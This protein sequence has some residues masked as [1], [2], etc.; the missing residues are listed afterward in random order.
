M[1]NNTNHDKPPI[2]I[3]K[4]VVKKKAPHHGGAW[5]I[6][7]AD[8]VTAMMA[9]FLL[10]WLLSMLNKYQ[11]MG[12]S[13]YFN[14]ESKHVF[15]ENNKNDTEQPK[16][17]I[18]QTKKYNLVMNSKEDTPMDAKSRGS[19]R[20]DDLKKKDAS[21]PASTANKKEQAA[22][23]AE[24]HKYET[25]ASKKNAAD[26]AELLKL[27]SKLEND[28]ANNEIMKQYKGHLSFK[29]MEDGL[30]IDLKELE[31]R[32]MFSSGK[33]DF[34]RYATPILAW[35]S[36]EL[37]QTNRRLVII[38]H[39]DANG[40]PNA[41]LYSNWELSADRANATRRALIKYGMS[42]DKIIRIQGAGSAVPLDKMFNESSVNRRIEIIVL[43]DEA[44]QKML[45]KD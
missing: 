10:M 20:M 3:I 26:K 31:N 45:S 43:T 21:K 15:V 34:E 9:F 23:K 24:D 17:P 14:K 5:K 30:K 6:A 18:E 22:A 8:F 2:I 32:P 16:V 11:L 4:R 38:G 36:L 33:V 41:K 27:K 19:S 28:L 25:Q 7:Y 40:Y 13:S 29:M 12:I 37:N 39:T 44:L 42:T 1:Q 35:L